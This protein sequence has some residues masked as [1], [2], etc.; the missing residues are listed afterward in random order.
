MKDTPLRRGGDRK[1][2]SVVFDASRQMRWN[3]KAPY[4][5]LKS[6]SNTVTSIDESGPVLMY[7][8]W[9]NNSSIKI[10]NI[11]Q[12]STKKLLAHLF[13]T[14]FQISG[15]LMFS[16]FPSKRPV[17]YSCLR[18]D[19]DEP[20]WPHDKYKITLFDT[21]KHNVDALDIISNVFLNPAFFNYYQSRH[22]LLG[23]NPSTCPNDAAIG[24]LYSK[25]GEEKMK[26]MN[27]YT[28]L[29]SANP[30]ALVNQPFT[31]Q[32]QFIPFLRPNAVN[33]GST[34]LGK[35]HGSILNSYNDKELFRIWFDIIP[36]KLVL[37][38][39]ASAL[40]HIHRG[41]QN[42][43]FRTIMANLT[44]KKRDIKPPYVV[45]VRDIW[46][47]TNL[48]PDIVKS[49]SL[50]RSFSMMAHFYTV[51]VGYYHRLQVEGSRLPCLYTST[52]SIASNR[53]R[54]HFNVNDPE[55]H[56]KS[57]VVD[58]RKLSSFSHTAMAYTCDKLE[59]PTYEVALLVACLSQSIG[60]FIKY[61]RR[62]GTVFTKEVEVKMRELQKLMQTIEYTACERLDVLMPRGLKLVGSP[63]V[64]LK[65]GMPD[66]KDYEAGFNTNFKQYFISNLTSDSFVE[67]VANIHSTDLIFRRIL[68]HSG[69]QIVANP[70]VNKSVMELVDREIKNNHVKT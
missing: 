60:E 52:G 50:V 63:S 31:S 48:I 30:A 70:D 39:N 49:G 2:S 58:M 51:M 47:K 20:S 21:M 66:P 54:V 19:P 1:H 4:I 65:S 44:A 24:T 61:Y 57:Y 3:Y 7:D 5:D 16:E 33:V 35:I 9:F 12:E 15:N 69:L 41:V 43:M 40:T 6:T 27:V 10:E 68:S 46:E 23:K 29:D 59:I 13:D 56:H 45:T 28:K 67:A 64:K 22:K 37:P 11:R 8:Y 14:L 36:Y 55:I 26:P 32:E 17:Q 25:V 53:G 42:H 62:L 34:R 38:K 18:I